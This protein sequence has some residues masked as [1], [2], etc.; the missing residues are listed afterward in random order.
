[1]IGRYTLP[2]MQRLWSDESK[3]ELWARIE[4]LAAQALEGI[5]VAPP[6]AVR[7]IEQTPAPAVERVAELER[8]RDHEMLAF[9]AAYTEPMS[10]DVARWVHRGMTSYDVVDTALGFTLAAACDLVLAA[11]SR[12]LQALGRRAIEHWDTL[13]AGRTHG[14]HA[15]PTTLGQKLA[16]HAFAVHR[17]IA[18]LRAARAVV[19]VGT[20]SGAVGT[21]AFLDPRV[22]ERVCAALGLAVEPVPSQVV[23]R[24]RHAELLSALAV[25]GAV[26]EQMALEFRLLQRTE[27]A[28]VEE[29]RTVDYQGSSAMPH[30]R[31][32]TTCERLCGLARLL[33]ANAGAAYENV[34]LWHERDLAHQ[35]VERVILPDSLMLAHFQI[36]AAADL[37][38]GLH[39]KPE[40]MRENLGASHGLIYSSA[41]YLRLL[42]GG[43]DR[44]RAYRTVQ[45]VAAQVHNGSASFAQALSERGISAADPDARLYLNNRAHLI[46]RLKKMLEE[47][48]P[49]V[50]V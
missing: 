48:M 10:A 3:Y 35:S 32:P 2:T 44:E 15:E 17:S 39:I 33:R 25:F 19:A 49:Y 28:E 9:L 50:E 14:V 8:S 26:V 16:V 30:K 47:A 12:L 1:M 46:D 45:D 5:G 37:V 34:A 31:N 40:R 23:A 41:S 36:S 6:E 20:I 13:C 7:V 43:M 29:P 38:H 21:Y 22:E 4:V 18:R 27:V 42:S 11:G 24:D